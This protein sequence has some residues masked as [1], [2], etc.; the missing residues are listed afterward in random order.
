LHASL[1]DGETLPP[2][3]ILVTSFIPSAWADDS[4]IAERKAGLATYLSKLL[5]SVKYKDNTA[6]TRFLSQSTASPKELNLEDALPSTLSRKAALE[7]QSKLSAAASSPIAAAYYPDWSADSWPPESLDYSKF[8][9]IFFGACF[10]VYLVLVSELYL[11]FATPNSSS[12]ISYDS[13][14]TSI[15]Q[16]LVTAAHNSGHG[17]KVVLSIGRFLH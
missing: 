11:A 14:S 9:V 1:G 2:K 10:L 17:T 4:L 8:D 5:Q 7:V 16:R 3:R 13:G 12:G 6:L 15:L